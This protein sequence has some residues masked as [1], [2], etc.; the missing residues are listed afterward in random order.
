MNGEGGSADVNFA[1]QTRN[2]GVGARGRDLPPQDGGPP[3]PRTVSGSR[4][5]PV[6]GRQL[7]LNANG[8]C[9]GCNRLPY[10]FGH[11]GVIHIPLLPAASLQPGAAVAGRVL[12]SGR[13][14]EMAGE[15]DAGAERFEC[16]PD[17]GRCGIVDTRWPSGKERRLPAWFRTTENIS[18]RRNRGGH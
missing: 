9:T 13:D 2:Q 6:F 14:G 1:H 10:A 8:S 3:F 7:V 11:V 16:T 4:P 17:R 15:V 12:L 5:P 18:G